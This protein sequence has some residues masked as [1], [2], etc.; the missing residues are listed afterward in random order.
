MAFAVRKPKPR[1]ATSQSPW[2]ASIIEGSCH[3]ADQE[4]ATKRLESIKR[5]FILSKHQ[6]AADYPRPACILWI[7]GYGVTEE[8]AEEGFLGH[9]AIITV[10]QPNSKKRSPITITKLPSELKLH[11]QKKRPKSKHPDWGYHV[12]RG[13]QQGR[14]YFTA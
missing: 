5:Q 14:H 1:I 2:L 12:L 8:E 6:P 7:K 4:T 10:E 13:V 9:Y 3:F 11:P